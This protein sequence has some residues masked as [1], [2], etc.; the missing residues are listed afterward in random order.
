MSVKV[1]A[2]EQSEWWLSVHDILHFLPHNDPT[3][4]RFLV[5]IFFAA[6]DLNSYLLAQLLTLRFD[7][8]GPVKKLASDTS[9]SWSLGLLS[10]SSSSSSYILLFPCN[11][12]PFATPCK[13]SVLDQ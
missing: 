10:S 13:H 2:S 7:F 6:Q 4:V 9:I 3:Q 12:K 5:Q 1:V 11:F 8:C